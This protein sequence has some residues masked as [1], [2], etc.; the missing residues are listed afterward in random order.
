MRLAVLSV[1]TVFRMF[2][3]LSLTLCASIGVLVAVRVSGKTVKGSSIGDN[4]IFSE[5]WSKGIDFSLWKHEIT[6][7]KRLMCMCV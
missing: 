4:L 5:D 6:V 2:G 7:C 3:V 1:S